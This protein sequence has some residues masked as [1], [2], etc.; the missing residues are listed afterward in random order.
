MREARGYQAI[1]WYRS[2]RRLVARVIVSSV[3]VAVAMGYWT[4]ILRSREQIDWKLEYSK[5][6][7]KKRGGKKEQRLA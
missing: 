5:Q 3:D 6:G 2:E 7:P 1:D 4:D